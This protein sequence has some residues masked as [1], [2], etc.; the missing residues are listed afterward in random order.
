M[1]EKLKTFSKSMGYSGSAETNA[2]VS[3]LLINR[4]KSM[5]NL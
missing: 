4:E 3:L 1:N 2:I 5:N